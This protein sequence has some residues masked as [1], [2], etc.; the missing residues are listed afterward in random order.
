MKKLPNT[1]MIQ[2]WLFPNDRVRQIHQSPLV[3]Y[4]IYN[5]VVQNLKHAEDQGQKSPGKNR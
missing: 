1:I 3:I 2:T 4:G 5:T